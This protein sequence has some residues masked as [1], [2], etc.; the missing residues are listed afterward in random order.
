MAI[1]ENQY[2]ADNSTYFN[3]LKIYDLKN[4]FKNFK[5]VF[6]GKVAVVSSLV[7]SGYWIY[8]NIYDVYISAVLGAIYE[9][10]WLFMIP[11]LFVVP[12]ISIIIIVCN[13][14]KNSK[15]YLT[16]VIINAG[17][18]VWLHYY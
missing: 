7:V 1:A 5:K 18:F 6:T 8:G 13:K 11:L 9:I 12:L 3:L 17:T 2:F 4:A 16:S 14:F 15:L 10:L